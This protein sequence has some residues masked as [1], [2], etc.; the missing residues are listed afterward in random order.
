M[1]RTDV[2]ALYVDPLGVYPSLVENW[3][4]EHKDARTYGGILPI[5]AHPPCGPWSTMRHL[6]TR[7]QDAALGPLAVDQ[8]RKWGGVLEQPANSRLWAA[9]SLPAP[10][11]PESDAWGFSVQVDQVSWGHVARKTTWLYMVGI[12]WQQV[13]NGI[14]FGGTPTHWCSGSRNAPRGPVPEGIKVCSAQQRNRTPIAFANWL[15][16]LAA[17]AKVPQ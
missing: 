2:A 15:L 7:P 3:W 16:D 13:I 6:H 17:T 9:K 1:R 12:D 11:G 8:V 5:V 14:R 10:R 4:D